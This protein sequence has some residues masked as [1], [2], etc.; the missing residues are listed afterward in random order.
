VPWRFAPTG[1]IKEC[2]IYRLA[3]TGSIDETVLERQTRKGGLLD[4]LSAKNP[5]LPPVHSPDRNLLFTVDDMSIASRLS[6]RLPGDSPYAN[7]AVWRQ[8][9]LDED[10]D[11]AMKVG[12]LSQECLRSLAQEK[13]LTPP[14]R[15]CAAD[16]VAAGSPP[17]DAVAAVTAQESNIHLVSFLW[18]CVEGEAAAAPVAAAARATATATATA[19]TTVSEASAS[20]ASAP[21]RVAPMLP[22]AR[23]AIDATPPP[24]SSL[25]DVLPTPAPLVLPPRPPPKRQR[26]QDLLTPM[27]AKEMEKAVEETLS[28][29]FAGSAQYVL[30]EE[31]YAELTKSDPRVAQAGRQAVVTTLVAMEDDNSVMYREG[32]IQLV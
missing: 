12:E 28:K 25:R 6:T 21:A 11:R 20:G 22:A 8:I 32:R 15:C 31:L 13:L 24:P 5:K 23:D 3:C 29:L 4:M 2:Y 9:N 14:H 19:T 18:M 26:I 27:T 10:D 16:A 1:Q 7:E 30:F 17:L